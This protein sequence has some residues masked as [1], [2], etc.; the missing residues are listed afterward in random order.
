MK[1]SI[2]TQEEYILHS[3]GEGL[4]VIRQMRKMTYAD[5]ARKSGYC[6]QHV[7]NVLRGRCAD[8]ATMVKIANVMDVS[9]WLIDNTKMS[10][11][12]VQVNEDKKN[13]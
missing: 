3:I 9:F 11:R 12:E 4:N 13:T 5:L 6:L 2:T 8:F 1:R 10:V 7:C